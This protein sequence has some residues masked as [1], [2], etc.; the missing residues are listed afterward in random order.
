M[1]P[2]TLDNYNRTP[3]H[4]V[5]TSKL[6]NDQ[7]LLAAKLLLSYSKEIISWKDSNGR[8]ALHQACVLGYIDTVK[9]IVKSMNSNDIDMK[10]NDGN[11]PT[12]LSAEFGHV[13]VLEYLIIECDFNPYIRNIQG[14]DVKTIAKDK[15]DTVGQL[16]LSK[17]NIYNKRQREIKDEGI[18]DLWAR[19]SNMEW[20]A[21]FVKYLKG[22]N[23]RLELDHLVNADTSLKA[24]VEKVLLRKYN[25]ASESFLESESI[26]SHQHIDIIKAL[27]Y[28]SSTVCTLEDYSPL[29]QSYTCKLNNLL[30]TCRSS[31]YVK[32]HPC[33]V[34]AITRGI[35]LNNDRNLCRSIL[36]F[37]F[38]INELAMSIDWLSE[39]E[40]ILLNGIDDSEND[41]ETKE[42]PQDDLIKRWQF[43]V[44]TGKLTKEQ[45]EPM[46]EL[47]SMEGIRQ[48][49][50][51]A[52]DI[53]TDVL[54]EKNRLKSLSTEDSKIL[55]ANNKSLMSKALNFCFAGNPGTGKVRV[56]TNT[57]HRVYIK[58]YTHSL[59]YFY[60]TIRRQWH[61]SFPN[62]F[63]HVVLEAD[64]CI[65]K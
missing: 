3:L 44:K 41:L 36:S 32:F 5:F 51:I 63:Q 31:D 19:S 18:L 57:I 26:S 43:L 62:F 64:I 6:G 46:N 39:Q 37:A 21:E 53:Y 16:I 65:L 50:K 40:K 34:L 8:T 2:F 4:V 47:L 61:V 14:T 10:D 20:I 9:Y 58:F 54:A 45:Q 11:T 25:V 52:L 23:C 59:A 35:L 22:E 49:K 60:I 38:K 30:S 17:L 48:V 24:I 27:A 42:T 33:I 1:S 12:L 13:N 15:G 55:V 28:I 56:S 7:S 29:F